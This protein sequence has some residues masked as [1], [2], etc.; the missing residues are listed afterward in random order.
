M[1]LTAILFTFITASLQLLAQGQ[2]TGYGSILNPGGGSGN[3]PGGWPAQRPPSY[4]DRQGANISG[5]QL[6]GPPTGPRTN[7]PVTGGAYYVPYSYPVY[8]GGGGG[9]QQPQVIQVEQQPASVII[10]NNYIPDSAPRPSMREYSAESLPAPV[11][12]AR[13]TTGPKVSP[14]PEPIAVI[15]TYD[16]KPTV[17]LIALKDGS[18]YSAV[19]YW[20]EDGTLHYMTPQH[21]HNRASLDLV[22]RDITDQIN[23]ERNVA[24]KLGSR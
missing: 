11:G 2:P 17:Y 9:Y 20:V 14:E 19:A 15:N 3:R 10:N 7:V 8:V 23:R 4:A 6:P 5:R 16:S 12:P 24:L 22:D 18:V 1:R 13:T 21:T